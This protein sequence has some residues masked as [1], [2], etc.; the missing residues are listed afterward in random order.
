MFGPYLRDTEEHLDRC[1]EVDWAMTKIPRLV[2]SVG[3]KKK[4][5]EGSRRE[6]QALKELL[7]SH[8]AEIKSIFRHY[9]AAFANEIFSLGGQGFNEFLYRCQ[10]MEPKQK[11][12][13]GIAMPQPH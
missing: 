4:D 11:T 10:V 5:P 8:Y 6:T 9:S 2:L 3:K 12:E 13:A 1:F 7:R